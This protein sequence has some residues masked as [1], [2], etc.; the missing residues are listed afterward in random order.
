[1]SRRASSCERLCCC[2]WRQEKATDELTAEQQRRAGG[3]S[4]KLSIM[5]AAGSLIGSGRESGSQGVEAGGLGAALFILNFEER[6]KW[7]TRRKRLHYPKGRRKGSAGRW[8]VQEGD[9]GVPVE[10]VAFCSSSL[11]NQPFFGRGKKK[12]WQSAIE[13]VLQGLLGECKDQYVVVDPRYEW[14]IPHENVL[15]NQY[16][17]EYDNN[18]WEYFP[19]AVCLFRQQIHRSADS[20]YCTLT[21]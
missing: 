19:I 20:R 18:H 13:H 8:G 7:I 4:R 5:K 2:C 6:M 9:G 14:D 11:F 16:S 1:M 3:I 15:H 12:P 17:H 10:K 21:H